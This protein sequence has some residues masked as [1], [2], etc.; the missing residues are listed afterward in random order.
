[1]IEKTMKVR[2]PITTLVIGLL[3]L[4]VIWS[5]NPGAVSAG[6]EQ[7]ASGFTLRTAANE[8]RLVF[9]VTDKHGH[10]INNLKQNDFEILDDRKPPEE[11][12]SFHSETDLPL[13]V[14]LLIDTSQSVRD[15]FRFE[16]EAATEF[17]NQ[18]IRRNY[19]QA[20]IIGF[21]LKPEVTQDFTGDAEKLSDGIRRLRP[22]NLTAMYDAVH[23]ACRKLLKQSQTGSTRHVIILLSDGDDNSSS[24]TREQA[25]EMA[26]RAE[27]SVYTI[28]T[29]LT[30]S[31]G[32][33]QKNL[34]RIAEATGGRS[35]VPRQ[36]TEVVNAF[37][38]I[39]EE[40]RSQYAVSYKPAAFR[41]DQ[42]YRTIEVQAQNWKGLRIR[43]RK[44][45]RALA[46]D[47]APNQ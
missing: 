35:Y 26:Q 29:S 38:A 36:I 41:L 24:V 10:Y 14:G 45:Y 12:L 9:T 1:M 27:V 23:Y 44:G 43:S 18:T 47:Y 39:Q 11:I 19:D 21:A 8:V 4:R 6:A 32:R 37:A 7:D 40:L 22:G 34:E 30:R 42:H 5:Q 17:L 20:F 15:R 16:Q 46:R 33:G 28:S 31:G 3:F 2:R 25:I 13:Q